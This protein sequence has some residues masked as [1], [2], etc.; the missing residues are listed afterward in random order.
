MNGW[1]DGWGAV[2]EE[3]GEK[4]RMKKKSIKLR[5]M[6]SLTTLTMYVGDDADARCKM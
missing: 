2:R 3:M 4:K 6:R 1:V 5:A